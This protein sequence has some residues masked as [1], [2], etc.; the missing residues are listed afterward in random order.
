ME[1]KSLTD[2]AWDN[3]GSNPAESMGSPEKL[4]EM[5]ATAK[6]GWVLPK[7]VKYVDTAVP[8]PTSPASPAADM[9]KDSSGSHTANPFCVGF[10]PQSFKS[11]L[12][13]MPETAKPF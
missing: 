1:M 3:S 9:S 10:K 4:F 2:M 12:D 11:R 7:M 8:T 5:Q 6:P 13:A